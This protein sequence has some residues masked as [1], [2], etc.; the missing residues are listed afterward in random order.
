MG[1]DEVQDLLY[2]VG[3][4]IYWYNY[5]AEQLDISMFS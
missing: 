5:F 4:N 2:M 1:R 3:D